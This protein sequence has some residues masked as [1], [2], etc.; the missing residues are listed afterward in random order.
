MKGPPIASKFRRLDAE[1]LQAAKAEIEQL[2]REGIVQR[3]TSPWASPLHMVMKKGGMW[4]PCGDFRRLNLVTEPDTYPLP[5]ML[6]F[7]ARVAGCKVFSKIDHRKGYYQ[8]PMHPADIR[9]TAICTPFGLFEFCCMPFGLRNMGNTFQRKMDRILAGL[10]FVFCYLDDIIIASRDEQDHLEHLREVFSWLHDAGLVINA[11]KCVFAATAVEF[12]GHKVSATGLEPLRSHVQA[13][14][15]QLEP[16][17]ISKLQAFLGTVNF[18]RRFLPAAAR[19]LK[20]LT[21][22]LIGG[23]KGTEPVNLAD[24]QRA[25]F[26]GAMDA[27][28]AAT[29]LVHPS[30]GFQL[31]LIVDASADHIGGALRQRRWLANP[32]QPLCFFSRKLACFQAIRHFR[33]ML[34]GR[35]FTLFTDHKLLTTAVPRSTELWTAKQCRQ[36]AYIAEFTSDIQHIAGSD[37]VVADTLSRPPGGTPASRQ[38]F[39]VSPARHSPRRPGRQGQN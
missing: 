32:W 18:Y 3:S 29:C 14:L 12:L 16:T 22:L 19:I 35:R 5:N 11:E 17:N 31:S 36:L 30:Q 25:A 1:K 34:E 28:A 37:I 39:G 38:Q 9:K 13:V 8:I 20:Q 24:P 4:R 33:F 2:E 15:A 10:S 27:L 7:S 26:V 6:D 21:D 23:L